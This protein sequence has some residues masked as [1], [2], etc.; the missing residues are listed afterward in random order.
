MFGCL[1]V[2]MALWKTIGDFLECSGW[3]DALSNAGVASSGTAA[4]FLKCSH[5]TRTRQAH[6]V[7]LSA[8]AKLQRDAWKKFVSSSS[9]LNEAS[10][11]IWRRDMSKKSFLGD[12]IM[13][14][15]MSVL[16]FFR[17]HRT[18]NFDLYVESL[19][20]LVPWFFALNH[21]NYSR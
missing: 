12:L 18:N 3:T 2:E 14:F 19:Q 11:E 16:I 7:S 1:H 6:Q 17:A 4:S 10:F 5:L 21:H 20:N 13:E 8:L 15:E 9:E